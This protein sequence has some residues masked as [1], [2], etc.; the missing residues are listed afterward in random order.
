ME[1][2]VSYLIVGLLG[3]AIGVLF[4]YVFKVWQ[5]PEIVFDYAYFWSLATSMAVAITVFIPKGVAF[6][7]VTAIG[8]FFEIGR[9]H[10]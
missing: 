7:I 5:D 3:G 2:F 10:V 6:D 9:A 1:P 8:V 4:P